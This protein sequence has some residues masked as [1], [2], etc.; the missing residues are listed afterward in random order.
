MKFNYKSIKNISISASLLFHL[1]LFVALLFLNFTIEY[2]VKQYVELSFGTSGQPGSS[3]NIGTQ[4]N[5][6]EQ[7]SKQQKK[8]EAI[9]TD[10]EVK[11]VKLPEAKNTSDENIIA[12]AEKNKKK[13]D[14]NTKESKIQTNDTETSEGMGN[15]ANGSGSFG[16][17]IDWGG[18]GQRKIY[19][20]I[21]PEY[22]EGVNKEIDIRLR[23][24]ILP[25]GTVGNIFPL[26]KADT[27]LENAAINSLRQWRFEALDPS[28]KQTDQV[29][30][31]VFPY[32]LK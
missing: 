11:K 17:D 25:D 6:I 13:S 7:L 5:Q 8:S 30:V 10:N 16:Y 18:K 29:A 31:I 12:P 32:R 21:L 9:N 20:F 27:R 19:S 23:F 14:T 2:P 24:S 26:I 22:P 4:V 3:G 1:A 15:K 28:Q